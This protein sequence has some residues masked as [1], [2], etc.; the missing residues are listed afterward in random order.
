MN[1]FSSG[2]KSV[3]VYLSLTTLIR[4]AELS[5]MHTLKKLILNNTY[6]SSFSFPE[7]YKES[8]LS[9]WLDSF[10]SYKNQTALGTL[11]TVSRGLV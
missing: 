6:F 9:A 2:S 1:T 7:L 5:G 4:T 8:F 3:V 10:T 11:N